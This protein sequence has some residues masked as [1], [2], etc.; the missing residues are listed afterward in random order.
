M[1]HF[2]LLYI[3]FILISLLSL[4]SFNIFTLLMSI[5]IPTTHPDLN[6]FF[7]ILIGECML[8]LKQHFQISFGSY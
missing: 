8:S 4:P 7:M 3:G 1:V 5:S 6:L 2:L